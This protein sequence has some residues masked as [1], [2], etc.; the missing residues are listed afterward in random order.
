MRHGVRWQDRVRAG[1]LPAWGV[2]AALLVAASCETATAP[3]PAGAFR[4]EAP[5]GYEQLWQEVEQCSGLSGDLARITWHVAPADT[6][7]GGFWC[8]DG[9]DNACA[10]EWVAPHDI[11]LAGSSP[12]DPEGYAADAWTVK[13]EMLHDL[14]G[15]AGHPPVFDDC[16]LASR[17]PLG[18]Y[19]L[20]R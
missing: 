20:S 15:R 9:P 17:T 19:G 16:H 2:A 1:C 6:A 11:Y 10:G 8:A 18:T 5:P 3:R 7:S 14:V 12:A 13:H 4:I